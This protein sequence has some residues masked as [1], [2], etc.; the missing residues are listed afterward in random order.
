[1]LL[2]LSLALGCASA[3]TVATIPSKT[4]SDMAQIAAVEATGVVPED[5]GFV[6][7]IVQDTEPVQ[8]EVAK[9]YTAVTVGGVAPV[10]YFPVEVKE[11]VAAALPETV[12]PEALELN[13]LVPVDARNYDISY[14][15]VYATFAFATMYTPGQ[16]V[17]ALLGLYTGEVDE[18]GNYIVEWVT[19]NAE[20]NEDGT[21]RVLMPAD[22]VARLQAAPA[23]ALAV[24]N[25]PQ[26]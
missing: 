2:V 12:V 1:M 20:V 19:L 10:E 15:D 17:V 9:L 5:S 18:N 22:V 7:E 4:T 3:E 25:E 14:G 6:V 23:A 8:A 26:I 24:L 13:E 21:L 16:T 11:A